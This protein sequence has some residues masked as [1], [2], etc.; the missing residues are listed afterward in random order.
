MTGADTTACGVRAAPF[1]VARKQKPRVEGDEERLVGEQLRFDEGRG[2]HLIPDGEAVPG[3]A[4]SHIG[5][6][7]VDGAHKPRIVGERL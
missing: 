6:P 1:Q 4:L 2:G 7:I 3:V 5:E